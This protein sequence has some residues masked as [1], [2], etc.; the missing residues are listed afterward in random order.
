M[1]TTIVLS[2]LAVFFVIAGFV[3]GAYNT[4]TYVPLPSL[5][6]YIA[7]GIIIV[8]IINGRKNKGARE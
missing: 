2:V 6:L 7:G 5:L 1:T 8:I 3:Y 4:H